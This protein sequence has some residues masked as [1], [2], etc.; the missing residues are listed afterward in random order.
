MSDLASRIGEPALYFQKFDLQRGVA[1]FR[2]MTRAAFQQSSFLDDRLVGAAPDRYELPLDQIPASGDHAAFAPVRAIFHT[3][4]CCS[5][6]LSRALD[7]PGR[8]LVY[9]EPVHLHQ[10]AVMRRRPGEFPAALADRWPALLDFSRAMLAKAWRAGEVAVFKATD[11]CNNIIAD[12]L[13]PD[14][15]GTAIL[16]YSQAREFVASNLK[17]EGRRAFLRNFIA[18]AS[19][20]N[21]LDMNSP[22][23]SV[24]AQALSSG[25]AAAYVWLTQMRSYEQAVRLRPAQCLCLDA[26]N[27]LAHT[28]QALAECGDFLGIHPTAAEL[29]GIMQ[30]G[31]WDRHAKDTARVYSPSERDREMRDLS[32]RLEGEIEAALAWLA[33]YRDE[34]ALIRFEREAGVRGST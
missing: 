4:Y 1:V 7:I 24:D 11:S 19:R 10:L 33:R 6:L 17:S 27:L 16:L 30:S 13:A 14:G 31:I 12:V 22:L 2:G 25:E 9:R 26:S 32:A 5:T 18:R 21:A 8:T 3:A 28:R 15:G 29:D 34:G 20:E 23:H